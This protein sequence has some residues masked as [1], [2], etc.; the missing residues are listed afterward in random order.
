ME[1]GSEGARKSQNLKR[2]A[3]A[4]TSTVRLSPGWGSRAS[5]LART[6]GYLA[7]L[8]NCVCGSRFPTRS[9]P[10]RNCRAG[11]DCSLAIQSPTGPSPFRICA[12][13]LDPDTAGMARGQEMTKARNRRP[14]RR[15]RLAVAV[16]GRATGAL[17]LGPQLANP[18]RI[19]A[20]RAPAR[21]RYP[22]AGQ[23]HRSG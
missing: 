5:R 4:R 12:A 21:A 14:K 16:G 23:G 13:A 3:G 11:E 15:V 7:T 22:A 20:L 9:D 19:A 10:R 6:M 1:A 2:L 17:P 8:S 18:S